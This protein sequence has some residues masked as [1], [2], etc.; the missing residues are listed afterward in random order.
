VRA[1]VGVLTQRFPLYAWKL[2]PVRSR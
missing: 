2:A 1:R